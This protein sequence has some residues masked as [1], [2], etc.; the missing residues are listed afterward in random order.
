LFLVSRALR[1]LHEYRR[2]YSR[3]ARR[4]LGMDASELSSEFREHEHVTHE[5]HQ[6]N[7]HFTLRHRARRVAFSAAFQVNIM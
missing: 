1:Q 2:G 7:G 6:H 4:S 3:V 5:Q